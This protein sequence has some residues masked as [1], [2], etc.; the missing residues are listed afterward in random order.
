M[1]SRNSSNSIRAVPNGSSTCPQCGSPE[2]TSFLHRQVFK[3]GSGDAAADL[4]VEVPLHRC[5]SC[6]FEYFDEV[7]ERLRHEAVCRHLGVLAP[8]QVRAV[9]EGYAMS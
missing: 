9:R 3:Y 5:G 8:A 1:A 4:G 7:A 6:G 2:V